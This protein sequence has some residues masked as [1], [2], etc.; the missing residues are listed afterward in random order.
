[1]TKV[2]QAKRKHTYVLLGNHNRYFILLKDG[3]T[4]HWVGP[5]AMD[6]LFLVRPVRCV[7]FG[8]EKEDI[9]VVYDDGSWKHL[10]TLP[11]DLEEFLMKVEERKI[12]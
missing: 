11:P 1:M 2:L 5:K 4:Q 6:L 9:V 8:G 12:L 3:K 10:G 7:A